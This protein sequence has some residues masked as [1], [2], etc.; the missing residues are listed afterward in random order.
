MKTNDR[1][2][3]TV[4]LAVILLLCLCSSPVLLA[5]EKSVKKSVL[6]SADITATGRDEEGNEQPLRQLRIEE[7]LGARMTPLLNYVF[8]DENASE[9]PVRYAHIDEGNTDT[10]T[11]EHIHSHSKLSTY[12]HLLNIIGE[13]L[14]TN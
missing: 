14:S 11:I 6:L 8:F 13:R 9:L 2:E 5:Q 7:Y 3:M 4:R 10:F 12:Y 1:K